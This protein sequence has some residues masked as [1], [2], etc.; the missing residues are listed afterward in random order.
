LPEKRRNSPVGK[1]HAL[2]KLVQGRFDA[3]LLGGAPHVQAAIRESVVKKAKRCG[4]RELCG[5]RLLL[6]RHRHGKIVLI[7]LSFSLEVRYH[8]VARVYRLA[9]VPSAVFFPFIVVART[10]KTALARHRRLPINQFRLHLRSSANTIVPFESRYSSVSISRVYRAFSIILRMKRI[11][12]V[13]KTREL[14]TARL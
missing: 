13:D 1:R 12:I 9:R 11:K 2:E 8:K 7:V 5:L 4:D 3:Q 10:M 14:L 6:V